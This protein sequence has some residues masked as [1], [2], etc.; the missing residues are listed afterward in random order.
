VSRLYGYRLSQML[1]ATEAHGLYADIIN[2]FRG[3]LPGSELD[4]A[5]FGST[6]RFPLRYGVFPG[7]ETLD[8]HCDV[9]PVTR[10]ATVN[11][12]FQRCHIPEIAPPGRG[13]M[14]VLR[15]LIVC[16]IEVHPARLGQKDREPGMGVIG[17]L[18]LLLAR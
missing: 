16:G 4:Y 1:Q 14:L 10:V 13:D 3:N 6:G 9:Y 7:I 5:R 8:I 12:A 15:Y 11:D 18:Q 17:T 2:V